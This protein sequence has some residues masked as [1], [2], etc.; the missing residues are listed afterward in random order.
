MLIS[1]EHQFCFYH[2]P[3]TGG[4]SF[5]AAL[6]PFLDDPVKMGSIG[7]PWQIRHHRR[8]GHMHVTWEK[9]GAPEGFL[10]AATCRN[11]FSRMISL[12]NAF[13]QKG[14]SLEDFIPRLAAGRAMG[15]SF[16]ST[17][18]RPQLAWIKGAPSPL[19]LRFE[20]L[21]ESFDTLCARV[22]IPQTKIPHHLHRPREPF[23][24]YYS[25]HARHLVAKLWAPDFNRFD[26][27]TTLP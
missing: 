16:R 14:E 9:L 20:A 7:K 17:L 8:P 10:V 19:I 18:G 6:A 21:Q 2:I 22:G 15:S 11:P 24:T 23:P 27:P 25:E 3:K 12:Y 4:S 5:T 1:T 13:G 26:Y